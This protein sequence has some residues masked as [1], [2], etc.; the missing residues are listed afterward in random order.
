MKSWL[1]IPDNTDFTI[2]NL[3]YGMFD[4]NGVPTAG[5]AIG[6][7]I[8]NLKACAQSGMLDSSGI[9]KSVFDSPVLNEFIGQG[10]N[11]TTAVRNIIQNQLKERSSILHLSRSKLMLD[12]IG[13]KMHM[14]VR[15]GDY[16]DF[17]SS[18]EHATNVGKMFRPDNPLL[19]NWK[20]IPVGYHG[21][22]QP[23]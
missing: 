11:K 1:T 14:P 20:H 15:I 16:T 19:P 6:D 2:H 22:R 23:C 21:R 12:R 4:L 7:Y 8:I 18:L 10:K 17:Y 3:P 5:M 9:D 13:V